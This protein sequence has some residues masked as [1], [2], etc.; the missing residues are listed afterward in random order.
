MYNPLSHPQVAHKLMLSLG[1]DE[2]VTQGG[3]WGYRVTRGTAHVYGH[4]YCKAWHTNLSRAFPPS[5]TSHP[6]LF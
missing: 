4:E 1:H 2:Y 3:D 6:L 5:L